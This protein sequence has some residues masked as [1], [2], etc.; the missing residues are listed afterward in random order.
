MTSV[1][2]K[3]KII[4]KKNS[5][6]VHISKAEYRKITIQIMGKRLHSIKIIK[7]M[8]NMFQK[9]LLSISWDF[10]FIKKNQKRKKFEKIHIWL[11]TISLKLRCCFC[12]YGMVSITPTLIPLPNERARTAK[13]LFCILHHHLF[14]SNFSS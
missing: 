5:T 11:S 7:I 14:V 12:N 13:L 2:K 6:N 8:K 10:P 1:S 4:V 3:R 9:N